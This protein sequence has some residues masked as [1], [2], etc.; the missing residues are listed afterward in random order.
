[1]QLN[2]N[3]HQPYSWS[4][5][6]R[7]G[8]RTALSVRSNPHVTSNLSSHSQKHKKITVRI[9]EN[10]T[11]DS[12]A[13]IPLGELAISCGVTPQASTRG[14]EIIHDKRASAEP[15]GRGTLGGG[16]VEDEWGESEETGGNKWSL[17]SRHG[18]T[19][20]RRKRVDSARQTTRPGREGERDV[21]GG[22]ERGLQLSCTLQNTK[23]EIPSYYWCLM[24]TPSNYTKCQPK[25][26]VVSA[27]QVSW[28]GWGGGGEGR[29][30]QSSAMGIW[31]LTGLSPCA[32]TG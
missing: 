25:G 2:E 31:I 11:Q 29:A 19:E 32:R 22:D 16:G 7:V 6:N 17:S 15:P 30:R 9:K 1:M 24:S 18:A 26:D 8:L 21:G 3:K 5:R 20:P 10:R 23:H 4:L 28:S 13:A 14:E 12:T 27:G